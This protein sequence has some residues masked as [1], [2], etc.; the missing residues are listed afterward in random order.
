MRGTKTAEQ[1]K[2]LEALFAERDENPIPKANQTKMSKAGKEAK[3]DDFEYRKSCM[4]PVDLYAHNIHD[5]RPKKR[6]SDFRKAKKLDITQGKKLKGGRKVIKIKIMKDEGN[7]S[8][9]KV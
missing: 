5:D 4:R 7:S 9:D 1:L 2:A 6:D 8:K 3:S